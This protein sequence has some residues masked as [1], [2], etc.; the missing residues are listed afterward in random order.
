[1]KISYAIT[2]CTEIQEIEK[3]L[4]FV[5]E[6]K[7]DEDNIVVLF[8]EKNGS[9][10][11]SDFLLPYD[12]NPNIQIWTSRDFDFDFAAWKNKLNSYCDGDYIFQLD[13]DE[14]MGGFLIKNL[15]EILAVNPTTDLFYVPRVNIVDGITEEHIKTWKWR[16]NEKGWINFP[17]YQGRIYKNNLFW[18]GRVHEKITGFSEY[19][20]LP[21]EERFSIIHRKTIQK[22]TDQNNLYK[23][24]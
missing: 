15:P 14:L 3:L 2:V 18:S 23:Q 17:D 12:D 10:E 11:V 7:R 19:S 13:A 8:D 24:I 9:H 20:F 4:P 5:V 6:N 1:M 16:I 21:L 22:Q